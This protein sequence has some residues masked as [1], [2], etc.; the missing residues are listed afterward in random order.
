[1]SETPIDEFMTVEDVMRELGIKSRAT[2]LKLTKQ[3]DNPLRFINIKGRVRIRRSW[4]ED[5]IRNAER[6]SQRRGFGIDEE[7]E[8]ELLEIGRNIQV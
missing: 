5:F 7:S 8:E 4:F 6:K 3:D 1:M 2:V